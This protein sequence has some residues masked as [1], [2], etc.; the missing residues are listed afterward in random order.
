MAN[1]ITREDHTYKHFNS[2][3]G[4]QI[5]S[6]KHYEHEMNKRGLIP[7]DKADDIVRRVR[8]GQRK[9]PVLSK[10]AREVINSITGGRSTWKK[11]EKVKLSDRQIDGMKKCGMTLDFMEKI[12]PKSKDGGWK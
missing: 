4:I 6:R 9:T 12:N 5:E 1:I 8:E 10:D 3:M 11:G 2:A 7:K